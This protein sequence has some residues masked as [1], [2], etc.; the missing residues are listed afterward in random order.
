MIAD[1]SPILTKNTTINA[2]KALP[3]VQKVLQIARDITNRTD[4]DALGKEMVVYQQ[5]CCHIVFQVI[6]IFILPITM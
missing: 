6:L 5:L 1:I 3:T 4:L 2:V